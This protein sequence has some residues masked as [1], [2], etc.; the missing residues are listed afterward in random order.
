[1]N[2]KLHWA[3]KSPIETSELFSFWRQLGYS[4]GLYIPGH[5]F[6][7]FLFIFPR[8]GLLAFYFLGEPHQIILHVVYTLFMSLFYSI[9]NTINPGVYSGQVFYTD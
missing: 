3:Q 4:L 5:S 8:W 2:F 6:E 9:L 7:G 1:M